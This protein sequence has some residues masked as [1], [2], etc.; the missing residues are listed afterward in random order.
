MSL[1]GGSARVYE[2]LMV[3]IIISIAPHGGFVNL[4]KIQ[5]LSLGFLRNQ[6]EHQIII[7]KVI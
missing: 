4:L 5:R 6:R 2:V 1:A 7:G 3:H